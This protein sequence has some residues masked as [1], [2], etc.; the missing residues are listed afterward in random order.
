MN[1]LNTLKSKILKKALIAENKINNMYDYL[2]IL[3]KNI[4]K[5]TDGTH[6]QY[7]EL[8]NTPFF[9]NERTRTLNDIVFNKGILEAC[10]DILKIKLGD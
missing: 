10:K 3:H 4:D 1:K 9:H 8:A 2:T 7:E 5:N 6:K